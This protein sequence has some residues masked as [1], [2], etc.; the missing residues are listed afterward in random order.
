MNEDVKRPGEITI[1]S[2][3]EERTAILREKVLTIVPVDS[4]IVMQ[5]DPDESAAHAIKRFA[6]ELSLRVNRTPCQGHFR[7]LGL[8]F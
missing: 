8:D 7:K 1:D 6:K 2:T 5:E 4:S 3:D